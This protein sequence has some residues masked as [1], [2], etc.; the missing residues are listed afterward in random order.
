MY[1]C[2]RYSH[3]SENQYTN[4]N[5]ARFNG[6]RYILCSINLS[7]R[8]LRF[9]ILVSIHWTMFLRFIRKWHFT[10][11]VLRLG[12]VLDRER[13]GRKS[14]I[15]TFLQHFMLYSFRICV[16]NKQILIFKLDVLKSICF[17]NFFKH[18]FWFWWIF[19][20]DFALTLNCDSSK[21]LTVD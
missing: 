3:V 5:P 13:Y 1:K 20:L 18:Q 8:N 17:F 14:Y 4:K 12:C 16:L 19:G 9:F 15:R 7:F 10:D 2:Q 21:R 11:V 6:L